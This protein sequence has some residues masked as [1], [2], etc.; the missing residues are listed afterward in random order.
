[1]AGFFADPVQG[2]VVTVG[3]L[4]LLVPRVPVPHLLLRPVGAVAGAS[5]A[6]YLT[7]YAVYPELLAVGVVPLL[8]VLACLGVG[9]VGS[10]A[11]GRMARA[12]ASWWPPGRVPRR[13]IGWRGPASSEPRASPMRGSARNTQPAGGTRAVAVVARAE[14]GR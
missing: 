13:S 8:V 9:V 12:A 4:S 1:M 14:G 3:L 10:A 5:L 2:A 7:H 6:I 11:V